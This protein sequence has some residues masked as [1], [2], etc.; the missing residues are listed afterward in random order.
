MKGA[1]AHDQAQRLRAAVD[2]VFGEPVPAGDDSASSARSALMSLVD[3]LESNPSVAVFP[4]DELLTTGE[5][6]GLLGISRMT[7]VRLIDRG[8]LAAAG[9]GKHRH[10]AV[11]ELARY[12][13]A[14]AAARRQALAGLA[15]DIDEHAPADQIIPTR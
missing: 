4:V 12:R 1:I 8:E 7:V 6:A 9:G 2:D 13:A 11:S 15:A 3:V 10:V 5:A 14:R